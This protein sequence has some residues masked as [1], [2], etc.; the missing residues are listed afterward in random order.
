MAQFLLLVL[1]S[2]NKSR[3]GPHLIQS[4][5]NMKPH[6]PMAL[7]IL[8]NFC[9]F[10]VPILIHKFV[11]RILK[12]NVGLFDYSHIFESQVCLSLLIH[13]QYILNLISKK[14]FDHVT[15][16]L[17]VCFQLS[18]RFML[19]TFNITLYPCSILDILSFLQVPKNTLCQAPEPWHMLTLRS[20]IT[21]FCLSGHLLLNLSCLLL[22]SPS[23]VIYH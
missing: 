22:I 3:S 1:A 6:G 8:C 18:L 13:L 11:D 21:F 14:V 17:K 7:T 10:Y 20:R 15:L 9:L 19:I 16:L 12:P 23:K 2:G 5:F 4:T